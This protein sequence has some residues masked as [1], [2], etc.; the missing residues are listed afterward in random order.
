[1][2]M[3]QLPT[4]Y[5]NEINGNVTVNNEYVGIWKDKTEAYLK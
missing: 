5:S 2:S 1:M 3:V 4:F